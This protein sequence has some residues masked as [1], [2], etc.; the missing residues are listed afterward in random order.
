MLRVDAV[1]RQMEIQNM[2]KVSPRISGMIRS[3]FMA[4]AVSALFFGSIP[5][6]DASVAI[7]DIGE[8]PTRQVGG[9]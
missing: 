9:F 6:A 3:A 8:V 2:S 7:Y 5:R 1:G 4:A